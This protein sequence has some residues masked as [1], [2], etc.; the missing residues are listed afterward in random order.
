MND[1]NNE[2]KNDMPNVSDFLHKKHTP[3]VSN[4]GLDRNVHPLLCSSICLFPAGTYTTSH[5][6]R[7]RR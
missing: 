3:D 4:G 6:R 7:Y 2:D 5:E 1:D